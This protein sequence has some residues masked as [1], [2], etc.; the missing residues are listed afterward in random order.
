VLPSSL[1]RHGGCAEQETDKRTTRG[2]NRILFLRDGSRLTAIQQDVS[3]VGLYPEQS[4]H[5]LYS[6]NHAAIVSNAG[7]PGT[8]LV[9][10][11]SGHDLFRQNEP[12]GSIEVW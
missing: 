5:I 10:V 12:G 6:P 11:L 3:L 1:S 9:G 4:Q 8:F 7:P 2:I